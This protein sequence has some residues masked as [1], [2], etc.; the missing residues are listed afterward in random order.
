MESKQNEAAV[1]RPKKAELLVKYV[2]KL[3]IARDRDRGSAFI[4]KKIAFF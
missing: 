1:P 2:E 4:W 3:K